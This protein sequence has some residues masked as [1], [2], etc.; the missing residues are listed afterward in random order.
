MFRVKRKRLIPRR[1][2]RR[3]FRRP[4]RPSLRTIA[5]GRRGRQQVGYGVRE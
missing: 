1:R 4:S 5:L 2:K 3:L